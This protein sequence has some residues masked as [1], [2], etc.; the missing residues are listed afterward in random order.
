MSAGEK[1]YQRNKRAIG[2]TYAV[3]TTFSDWKYLISH[4]MWQSD[5]YLWDSPPSRPGRAASNELPPYYPIGDIGHASSID[6]VGKAWGK[7]LRSIP[8]GWERSNRLTRFGD[9]SGHNYVRAAYS[10]DSITSGQRSYSPNGKGGVLSFSQNNWQIPGCSLTSD[11]SSYRKNL[12]DMR[13]INMR[14][15]KPKI[16]IDQFMDED[17]LWFHLGWR[18]LSYRDQATLWVH[19][20]PT[21][22]IDRKYA[23]IRASGQDYA[24]RLKASQRA[25]KTNIGMLQLNARTLKPAERTEKKE[26]QLAPLWACRIF[27]TIHKFPIRDSD[28]PTEK[29]IGRY[30]DSSDEFCYFRRANGELYAVLRLMAVKRLRRRGKLESFL[31]DCK[32]KPK[33]LC[34]FAEFIELRARVRY[35]ANNWLHER[36]LSHLDKC[37]AQWCQQ[38]CEQEAPGRRSKDGRY[39]TWQ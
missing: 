28:P 3:V 12:S 15:A 38:L 30:P 35:N 19:Y 29:F 13:I 6:T 11:S 16:L 5:C 27:A 10:S 34:H 17:V 26:E 2:S 7:Y 24:A 22:S 39:P 21:V 31:H 18:D 25:V 1:Y 4:D 14:I 8:N 32:E 36:G 37:L 33:R 23:L 20:V 9:T